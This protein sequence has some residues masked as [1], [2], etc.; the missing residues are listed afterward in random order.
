MRLQ[1]GPPDKKI[2][3]KKVFQRSNEC[4]L[5]LSLTM[6]RRP[7][8]R[9]EMRSLP[10]RAQTIVLWA[11]ETAGPWSAVTIRHISMNWQAYLGNLRRK[12]T[13]TTAMMLRG[14]FKGSYHSCIK[15]PTFSGTR[16]APEF[17]PG[18]FLIWRPQWWA[19]QHRWAPDPSHHRYW[20]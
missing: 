10:A 7:E 16:A 1:N 14:F 12:T 15:K 9:L 18:L 3:D 8:V 13:T 4:T 19:C 20:S 5:S 17:P 11:P 6:V 2:S